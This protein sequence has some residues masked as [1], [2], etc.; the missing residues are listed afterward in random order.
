MHPFKSEYIITDL[1]ENKYKYIYENHYD[2]FIFKAI[3]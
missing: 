1:N 3:I 2:V